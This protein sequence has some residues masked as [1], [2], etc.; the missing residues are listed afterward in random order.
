MNGF[1]EGKFKLCK[2]DVFSLGLVF[3]QLFTL[4]DLYGLNTKKNN[5]DL[6]SI[7]NNLKCQ[8]AK[9]IIVSMLQINPADRPKFK[10]LLE[11]IAVVHQSII[12]N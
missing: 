3:L 10:E 9:S 2:S 4:R 7:V 8:W 1:T 11:I 5:S 6:L 12:G